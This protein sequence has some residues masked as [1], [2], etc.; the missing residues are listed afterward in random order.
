VGRARGSSA[1]RNLYWL[2]R[3]SFPS[4]SH[5]GRIRRTAVTRRTPAWRL[6][7]SLSGP[8]YELATNN[9]GAVVGV[10]C[11]GAP[12]CFLSTGF[13]PGY[14]Q[15]G[16]EGDGG[17][18][19]VSHD[20]G[21][22]WQPTT[23]PENVNITTQVSCVNTSWCA[24]GAGLLDLATGDPA[25]KKP[26]K[27]PE[28]VFTTDGGRTWTTY[29]VPIPVDVQQLP[30]YGS[31]PAETT[32]WPGEV[33]S[34]SCSAPGTCNVI[35]QTGT[36]APSGGIGDE[37]VFLHTS[38]A[39][40][41]WTSSILPEETTELSYQTDPWSA[42]IACPTAADCVVVGTL[43]PVFDIQG[44]HVDTWRTADD[45]VSWTEDQA[46]GVTEAVPAPSISCP[47]VD[48]CWA[49]PVEG[50]TVSDESVLLHSM[51]GGAHWSLVP[52]PNFEPAT[53]PNPSA[54]TSTSC[55]SAS[56]CS[57]SGD[58]IAET[59]N[60]GTSWQQVAL[61]PQVGTVPQISCNAQEACVAVANPATSGSDAFV[62]NLGS[63]I[64][65]DGPPP[66]ARQ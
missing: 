59:T 17:P 60:G 12:T 2:R 24:A 21:V 14:G 56:V 25:A 3:W 19:Y 36:N 23:L 65:T 34:L 49:G 32:Y 28:F 46:Q 54:W 20:D 26:S 4:T 33:D 58:G 66:S 47:E 27:D 40:A 50:D 43:F 45:G 51:D 18:T 6:T 62:G 15:G 11:S 29:A 10:S 5:G 13:G 7:A 39:G 38:D 64:L 44:G 8:Q 35:G 61:P 48:N 30:A 42:S 37:F 53:A 22:T 1:L 41:H 31:L 52:L 55:V 63:L 16:E 9:P 57:V